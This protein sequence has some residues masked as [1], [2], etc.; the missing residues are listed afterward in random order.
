MISGKK[1]VD[2]SKNQ[3]VCHVICLFSGSS[4]VN[5]QLCQVSSLWDMYDRL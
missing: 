3:E 5:V 1:N 4:L 2:V